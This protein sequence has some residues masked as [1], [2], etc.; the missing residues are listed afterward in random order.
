LISPEYETIS[1]RFSDTTAV[2]ERCDSVVSIDMSMANLASLMHKDTTLLLQH[3]G[4]WR[5][6]IVGERSPWL[7]GPL[8]IRQ[9]I[10]GDWSPVLETARTQLLM[11]AL[12]HVPTLQPV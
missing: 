11:K 8:C 10:P 7:A 2:I 9:Q 6:G 1:F 12:S 4:E 3:E 5:F